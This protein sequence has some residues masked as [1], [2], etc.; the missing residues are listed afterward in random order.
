MDTFVRKKSRWDENKLVF[1]FHQRFIGD[2][3]LIVLKASAQFAYAAKSCPGIS[4][5]QKNFNRT[6]LHLELRSPKLF[7]VI[8]HGELPS[9]GHTHCTIVV[10]RVLQVRIHRA[11]SVVKITIYV[12]Q[13]LN[14]SWPQTFIH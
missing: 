1:N 12:S 8:H 6:F 2:G 4:Y 3:W 11:P 13:A 9:A 14:R 10:I 7:T 5:Y